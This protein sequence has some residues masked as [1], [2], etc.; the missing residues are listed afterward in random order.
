V[1]SDGDDMNESISIYGNRKL[2]ASGVTFLGVMTVLV[3]S[4]AITASSS[5]GM[6]I[7]L[8]VL[9]GVPL[10]FC[11]A[12]LLRRGPAVVIGP[13]GLSGSRVGRTIRWASI[14]DIQATR[15]RGAFGVYHDVVLR[16]KRAD[17]SSAAT[18]EFSIDLLTMRS[19]DVVALLQERMGHVVETKPQT[20]RSALRAA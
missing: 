3:V 11:V 19:S 13:A 5:V 1:S 16:V 2:L 18:V 4:R 9:F 20:L 10:A 12:A 6:T 15:H 7:F 14:S 8:A 17:A